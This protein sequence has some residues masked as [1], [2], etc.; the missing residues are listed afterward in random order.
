MIC[1][2][3][4]SGTNSGGVYE[5]IDKTIA[6]IPESQTT[7]VDQLGGYI[8]RTFN[9]PETRIRAVF[10]WITGHIR[11][12]VDNMQQTNYYEKEADLPPVTLRIRKGVCMTFSLPGIFAQTPGKIV[13]GVVV[14]AKGDPLIGVSVVLKGTT[15]GTV[16][17]IN[18]AF[19]LQGVKAADPAIRVSY[20][21]YVTQEVHPAGTGMK[22]VLVESAQTL[23]ELVVVGYG[24]VKKK[25]LTGAVSSIGGKDLSDK[26]VPSIGEALQGKAAGVQVINSGAPGSNVTLKIRGLGTI[27]NSDPLVVIDGFPTDLGLNALNAA[28]IETVDILKDA[29]ATAIY[30]ARGA[31]GVVMVTT[32]K[33]KEGKG[34]FSVLSSFGVQEVT[35]VPKMLNASQY[36]ALN[37]DMLSN[38]GMTTNPA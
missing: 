16:T 18:G 31:N 13:S 35:D 14:D 34:Q 37:N 38:A 28:D 9:T 6:G 7:T 10:V 11:Y 19:S 27:N 21:G 2:S 1:V 36:A 25:D 33:G 4:V 3:L 32:K 29:S 24:T 15:N 5:K 22:I 12:D 8:S 17:D 30:G 23:D 26:P 20:V